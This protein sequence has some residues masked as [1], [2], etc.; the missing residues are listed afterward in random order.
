MTWIHA[1]DLIPNDSRKFV[2]PKFLPIVFEV[3]QLGIVYKGVMTIFEARKEVR[4]PL[5]SAQVIE[6][7]ITKPFLRNKG[8]GRT[9][10]GVLPRSDTLRLGGLLHG[11]SCIYLVNKVSLFGIIDLTYTEVSV[12]VTQVLQ[13]CNKRSVK[14]EKQCLQVE[15]VSALNAY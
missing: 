8:G 12:W 6:F 4:T 10:L 5:K 1:R 9:L 2:K 3:Q 15:G 14:T 11:P 7:L 13:C